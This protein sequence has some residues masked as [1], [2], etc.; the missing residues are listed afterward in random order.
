M[1]VYH[2]DANAETG[3]PGFPCSQTDTD[4]M[5][6]G[7]VLIATTE[8]DM[9]IYSVSNVD[10]GI[11]AVKFSKNSGVSAV[12]TSDIRAYAV[13]GNI[14]VNNPNA[15]N[16]TVYTVAGAEVANTS[17]ADA[18]IA[19]APGLYIVKAGNAAQKILVK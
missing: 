10:L 18:S 1:T 6:T 3:D 2:R 11:K 7:D 9:V 13:N 4:G 14:V 8:N 15:E 16:V 19:V 5:C 12:E 17:A